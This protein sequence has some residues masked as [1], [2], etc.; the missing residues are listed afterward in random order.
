MK[1]T[2]SHMKRQ[3]TTKADPVPPLLSLRAVTLSAQTPWKVPN[4]LRRLCLLPWARLYFW[5]MGVRWERGLHL[6]G[7][8]IIQKYRPSTF[9]IAPN[10]ELR[11]TPRSNPLGPNHPVILTTRRANACLV[12]GAD[13]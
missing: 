8:P 1:Q 12:I 2:N 4:E 13:F 6:Y 11:S 5:L 7:L 9:S 3:P 10:A